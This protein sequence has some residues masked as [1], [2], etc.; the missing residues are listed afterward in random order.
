MLAD[1]RNLQDDLLTTL[2]TH[3]DLFVTRAPINV[4]P[5]AQ[6]AI[7]LHLFNHITK[8]VGPS[9][10]HCFSPNKFSHR[11]RRRVLKNNERLAHHAKSK[12][13]S[14]PLE[15]VQD[16]G[17][18]R[19]SVLVLL[20]FR[21]SAERWIAALTAHTPAPTW[22]VEH[23]ARFAREFG[24]PEGAADKLA[25]ASPG[26]YPF[27]HVETF[28]GNI[29]DSFRLGVKVTR[30]SVRLFAE[31]YGCDLIIASPLG[32]RLSI[33]KEKLV[34][35]SNLLSCTFVDSVCRNADFLSSIEILV[36]DQLDA[37]TMQNW[38]HLQVSLFVNP[39]DR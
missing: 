5:A 16:Q 2:S 25:D 34:P 15:D 3:Q 8:F 23:R 31:F 17:F 26:T 27:D 14:P 32:L 29:D 22:Q 12:P 39:H 21:N 35:F 18:T 24:L 38:E 6:T 1:Q 13:S 30:K 33:E 11:K 4:Q 10:S 19:P 7:A 28:K 37:L 9:Q 20:P 36:I